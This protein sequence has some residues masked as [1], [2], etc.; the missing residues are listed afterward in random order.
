MLL[1]Q[2]L[3]LLQSLL[4]PKAAVAKQASTTIRPQTVQIPDLCKAHQQQQQHRVWFCQNLQ[5]VGCYG[6]R[7]G[8]NTVLTSRSSWDAPGI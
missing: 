8:S 7:H 2:L 4:G 6:S 1:Q 5:P 3:L